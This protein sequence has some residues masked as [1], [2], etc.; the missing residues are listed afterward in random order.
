MVANY[1]PNN[2]KV[3]NEVTGKIVE[4]W[5]IFHKIDQS[6]HYGT[7]YLQWSCQN[8]AMIFTCQI[9]SQFEKAMLLTVEIRNTV[10]FA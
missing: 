1:S 7:T 6:I 8:R 10:E 5:Q 4:C 9:R 2:K 3:K